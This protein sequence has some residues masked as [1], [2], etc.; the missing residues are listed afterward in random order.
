[1]KAQQPF[2]PRLPSDVSA[3]FETLCSRLQTLLPEGLIIAFSGGVDSAFLVWAAER[4]RK[5]HGGRL[6]AL[7]A[8]SASMAEV[9]RV[10]A[11]RFAT[12]LGVEHAW[13]ESH[14]GAR[15]EYVANDGTRCYY[16]KSEL[17]RIGHEVAEKREYRW[18]AY[19]YNASDRGDV[20]PGHRAALE[21]AVLSPLADAELTKDDIRTLMRA[22]GLMLSEKPA[23]P[24]LAS[25]LMVGVSVTPEKLKDVEDMET[26]LRQAGLSVFRVRL[27]EDG[28]KRFLRIEVAPQE[29]ARAIEAREALVGEA[30]ARG[31]QWVTLDLAGYRMGGGNS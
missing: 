12:A 30:R 2:Q 3:K 16:C 26:I 27:H 17:F 8:V 19:G 9:E 15:R 5:Q 13:E 31:Y 7:T 21:N 28:A 1:M 6:L 22:H 23:S 24:C 18:L 11:R 25:R 10:D 20:R 14:E 4:V 29:M